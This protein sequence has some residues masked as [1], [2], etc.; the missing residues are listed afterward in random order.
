VMES[1]LHDE[2]VPFAAPHRVD[3]RACIWIPDGERVEAPD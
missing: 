3:L 2:D 1:L